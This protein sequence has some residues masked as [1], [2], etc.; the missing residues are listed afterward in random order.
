MSAYVL[1]ALPLV[2]G[3]VCGIISPGYM[4]V[5]WET[6]TGWVLIGIMVGLTAMGAFFLKRIVTIKG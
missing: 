4:S 3:V 6:T 5:M 2:V 1:T